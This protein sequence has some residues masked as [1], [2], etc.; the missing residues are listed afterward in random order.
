MGGIIVV[1]PTIGWAWPALWPL[2]IAAGAALGYKA[3]S[4]QRADSWIRNRLASKLDAIRR[5]SVPIDAVLADVIAE[6]LGAE[7]RLAFERDDFLLV[8]RKD[9]RGKFFVEVSGP[10][11]CTAL[12]LKIR[13][14]EFA[15][16]V[17]QRFAAHKMTELMERRGAVIL[18][19]EVKEQGKIELTG[20]EWH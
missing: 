11:E 14:E 9:A 17:A 20:R 12:N 10:R 8:F 2:A 16:E 6:D 18:T 15:R 3:M 13:G 19:E 1:I 4:E 5:V 7:E